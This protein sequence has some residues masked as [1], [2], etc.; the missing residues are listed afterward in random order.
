[1]TSLPAL[2][3]SAAAARLELRTWLS[4]ARQMSMKKKR[5]EKSCATPTG[6]VTNASG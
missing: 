5:M 6:I 2:Y 4:M 3:Y 1:M